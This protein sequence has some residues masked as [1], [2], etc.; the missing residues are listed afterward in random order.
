MSRMWLTTAAVFLTVTVAAV[1]AAP[2]SGGKV[3]APCVGID[4]G[5]T[6]SVVGVWQKGDVHIIPNEMGNRITPSVVA[7]TDTER[8]IGDGAKNQLPQNPHNTIYTIKRLIGRKYTDAAVQADKKLLSYEVIADRDGKP[9]VQVMVGG[10]KKQFT[11]EEISA[12]VLQKMKEIAE[13]YLGEKVKNAVVTVPA[14]FNDAQRQS[15]KDAGTIAGLNVVRIINEPTAAAIAYGLNK[16]GEK[17]ILVFDLGGGTFDVSL[18]TIDEGFFEVVAT[19]GDTHLGGEDF[20]NNMMRHFVD[21]LKKKKNVDISKDQKALAR[22]RKAC[23][24][25]KRQLSSHPEARVE[26]DSL[27]EGFDFSEKITRAKFEELN[28]DLFKGTLVPVQRVLE[29]AKLKKSDIHE[30]VLVGGSTR[31]PKVQQLISDFFGGK[32]LNRGINPDE[33]VAYGAAVQAA[34]LTGESEVGGRVVLVDVIPLSLGIE[35]V[36]GVMTKLIERN[37]QIPTKKSQVF[38]THADNQPGVLIQVYE[39]ERQLTKDNRLLGKFELSGIPPAARGVPQIE[40][41]FDVDENSI[42]QVSAMDKSSGKKEEITITNDK[43]RLSEE[44]IERM[45]RE[46]AEFED[47]DRKVRERVD[48]RNSLESV[49]YSLRN[50]VNDKDKLGGKL[51]P[52][53]K[54]AVETAVAEAIRFLDENPNAEKE[55][56]KTALETLQSVTNPIIQKTYQSAGGGDKPQP[57]DDL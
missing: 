26:V 5:T 39:G 47:E 31:V 52:N 10:K 15:T 27:T 36:G 11:P 55:E 34:V 38:S 3:E 42:L 12:M 44:E 29:D 43:G 18:L 28:M 1:S 6:Y 20:D 51:D 50:Q 41:T 24:A 35:T 30:I 33:A 45:V 2:E 21:M 54:A 25:A 8:L 37:T 17:N 4:L 53:D 56:Y 40:V 19:N 16:A 49:A 22:L 57:M 13:T 48:A 7:F 14:Y 23:E 9:K 32:E 46:A